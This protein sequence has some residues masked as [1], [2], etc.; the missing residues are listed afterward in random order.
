MRGERRQLPVL[1]LRLRLALV[2]EV[3]VREEVM[4]RGLGVGVGLVLGYVLHLVVRLCP[5][6]REVL[7][8]TGLVFYEGSHQVSR[9]QARGGVT[10]ET[11]QVSLHLQL[12][13]K[14]KPR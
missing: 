5:R 1:V 8:R 7:L 6:V 11:M 13:L 9:V 4:L 10:G 3:A 12:L 14:K 2:V